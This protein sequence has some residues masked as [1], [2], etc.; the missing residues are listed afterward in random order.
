MNAFPAFAAT[1]QSKITVEG[2]VSD[3]MGEPIIGASIIETGTVNGVASDIEGHFIINVPENA[4][5]RI[6]SLGYKTLEISVGSRRSLNIV[7]E[8]DNLALDEIVVVGYG[9]QQ[10]VNLSG[11]V[12]QIGA[13]DIA[14]RPIQNISSAL[15]GLM[16]G[17]TVLS[18]DGRPGMDGA[19][20]RVRGLGTLNTGYASPYILIDGVESGTMNSLD[21][22]DIESISVLK[23]ASSAA[24]YGSKAANGVIL[25]TTKRGKA[26]DKP[27]ITYNGFYGV[28]KATKLVERMTSYDYA[29]L[30]ADAQTADGLTPRFSADDIQKFKDGSDPFGHP[31]TDWYGLAFK[32]GLQHQH[33]V[34]VNGGTNNVTYMASAGFLQQEGILPN[35][36]RQQFNGRSN[37]DI[38]LSDRFT[39][40]MNLAYIRNDYSDP[41]NSYTDVGS[42]QIIRQLNV[43]APWIPNK[44]ADGDYGTI[45]DGNP[46][47]WLDLK[48]TVD[49][50]NQNFTGILAA[51][52]LVFDGLKLTLQEAYTNNIQHYREFRKDI[53]YNPSKYHGPNALDER[54]YL[55]SRNNFD[56]YLNYDKRFGVHGLKVMLGWHA[57]D[58]N[59]SENQSVR[60]NFPNNELTDINA[61][62]VSTQ[63][64]AGFTRRLAMLSGFGRLNYDYA[65]KYLFEANFRAD[66]SSRFAP[67]NRWGYFPSFSAA[68]RVSEESFMESYRHIVNNLKIR[69]SWGL[70]GDQASNGDYYPYLNTY[71]LG[72]TYPFG[73]SLETGYYQEYFKI[74]SFSWEKSRT[75]G[76]GLDIA[77]FNTVNAT[78]DYYDRKTTDIIM[79]VPV[80]AEFGLGAYKDNIGAVSNKGIEASLGYNN[81]WGD[82][83]RFGATAN[84][85]YNKNEILDLGGVERMI[86]EN[87]IKQ[88][89]S[90]INAYYVYKTDGFFRSQEEVDAFTAKYNRDSGTTMFSRTFK[91]GDLRY[92]DVNGDGKIN[93]DD[94]VICHSSTP[95]YLFGLNLNGG[96]KQ[97]DLSL[98]WSGAAGVSR[99]YNDQVFGSFTGDASHPS[100][101]WLDAWTP[102]NQSADVPRIWNDRNSNSDS[103]NIM[104]TFWLQ[105]TSYL[106]LKNLQLGYTVPSTITGRAGISNLRIYYSG[107]NL[108][109]FDALRV[110]LDPEIASERGSSYPLIQT[111]SIGVNVTF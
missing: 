95:V 101:W 68:W 40:R 38:A 66:A 109:T 18:G 56:A 70:L 100:T 76:V 102:E 84:F 47:A 67:E 94:R 13:G 44:T 55:W 15:Q 72:G 73:G 110:N 96:F 45:S 91:P 21:P 80:P 7:L 33:N 79:D 108:F 49:R 11:S 64:N 14:N 98:I 32:N 36:K 37:L 83:W 20:I 52:Y 27:R 62:T 63:T 29:R 10:K 60:K 69:A 30:L 31:N 107:E 48:Q 26:G 9:T 43:I 25:I 87:S 8:E 104:S 35:S 5:L 58:Y 2:K 1:E 16:T 34:N 4:V 88:I 46:I 75:Y 71:S 50:K 81:R 74:A 22:N 90:Q 23:D 28:Q 41:T 12:A 93:G 39:V 51:D 111:H 54:F 42:D 19:T 78:I 82:R 17:V 99:I 53:W 65:G 6:S 3:I 57:E 61:G 106:R 89:G 92:V 103:R 86:D 59:Y 24:I 85:S 105:N 77:L 97:F